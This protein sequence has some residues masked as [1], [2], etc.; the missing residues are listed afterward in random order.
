VGS[1]LQT[2]SKLLASSKWSDSMDWG[3][4]GR[5]TLLKGNMNALYWIINTVQKINMEWLS[6]HL[7]G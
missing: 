3:S 2:L 7:G 4:S 1:S 5:Q 6:Y